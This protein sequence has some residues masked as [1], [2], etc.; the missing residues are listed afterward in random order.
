[1][2]PEKRGLRDHLLVL[3]AV[4]ADLKPEDGVWDLR[5]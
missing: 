3:R 1:M 5:R 4:A 2:K